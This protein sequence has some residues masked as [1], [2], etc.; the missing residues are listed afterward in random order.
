MS[1]PSVIHDTFTVER[2]YDALPSRVFAA[3]SNRESKMRWNGCHPGA[4]FEMDF[5]VGGRDTFRGGPDGGP[6]YL[7]D[8]LYHD[9]VPERRIVLS[10][11]M[12][13]DDARI[14]V[15][16][17]TIELRPE[18]GGTRLVFTEQGVYL[19]GQAVSGP[20]E[21]GTGSALDRLGDLL[22]AE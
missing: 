13:A 17:Q 20:R 15:S 5:R 2:V 7:V 8:T 9:I 22:K 6:V 3:W 11:D 21:H 14:S 1:E 18:G 10:Y 12:Y 4:T 19:D 16:L